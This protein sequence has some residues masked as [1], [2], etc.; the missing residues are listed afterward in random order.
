MK[1]KTCG[2]DV[3]MGSPVTKDCDECLRI[4]IA[5][6]SAAIQAGWKPVRLARWA[7]K[8]CDELG[9]VPI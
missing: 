4:A 3:E 2:R 1:C 8:R 7:V 5:L 9:V 6:R